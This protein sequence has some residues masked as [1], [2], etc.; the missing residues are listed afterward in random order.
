M[1][2]SNLEFNEE[3]EG[4]GEGERR[5]RGGE[6][7]NMG[8]WKGSLQRPAFISGQSPLQHRLR[9][10]RTLESSNSLTFQARQGISYLVIQFTLKYMTKTM[11]E[12][13][14]ISENSS[15]SM[16]CFLTVL[17]RKHQEEGLIQAVRS[18]LKTHIL[19]K[20]LLT[21]WSYYSL[22]K[23]NKLFLN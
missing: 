4:G 9:I 6:K 1:L 19:T 16:T 7:E 5:E 12:A 20:F 10:P 17:Q 21:H 14:T 18:V 13:G 23:K 8:L 22:K 15:Q 11:E 3:W 2:P